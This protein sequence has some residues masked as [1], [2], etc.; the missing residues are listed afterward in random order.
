MFTHKY[1]LSAK[2]SEILGFSKSNQQVKYSIQRNN[3]VNNLSNNELIFSCSSLF[4]WV[5]KT[6]LSLLWLYVC[7]C[8][9]VFY[10]FIYFQVL[11]M[12]Q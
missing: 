10:L 3:P 4:F 12:E 7:V 2:N 9:C 11:V 5:A 1:L 8:V 6:Q